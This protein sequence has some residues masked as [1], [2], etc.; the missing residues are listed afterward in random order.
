M[1]TFNLTIQS[2]G[3]Y[4]DISKTGF[5]RKDLNWLNSGWQGYKDNEGTYFF[6]AVKII[7]SIVYYTKVYYTVENKIIK[8]VIN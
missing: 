8:R 1:S 4:A 5:N 6:E 3:F 7:K 2:N